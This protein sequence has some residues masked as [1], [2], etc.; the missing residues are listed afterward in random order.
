MNANP[1]AGEPDAVHFLVVHFELSIQLSL[2]QCAKRF[3]QVA[4]VHFKLRV[5]ERHPSFDR[6]VLVRKQVPSAH[7]SV[8]LPAL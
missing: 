6:G 1:P 5:H 3:Y 2:M 8:L 7:N 4:D